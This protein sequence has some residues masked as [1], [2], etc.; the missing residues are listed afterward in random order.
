MH[1]TTEIPNTTFKI[2]IFE[3]AKRPPVFLADQALQDINP[4]LVCT[5]FGENPTNTVMFH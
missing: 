3:P 5:T 4:C 2:K 1:N